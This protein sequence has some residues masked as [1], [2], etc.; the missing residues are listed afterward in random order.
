M[1]VFEF[2]FEGL[3]KHHR[4]TLSLS[5]QFMMTLVKLRLNLCDADLGY[6]FGVHQSTVSRLVLKWID[7]MY[8]RLTPL[9]KWPERGDLQKSL[10]SDFS[11]N[12]QRCVCII[13]CFEIFCQRPSDLMARAL[14]YSHYKS[15][16]TVKYLSGIAPQ[17]VI[18]FAN[19][20][21]VEEQ[22]TSSSQKTVV[23]WISFCQE[24]R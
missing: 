19:R 16:N 6:R 3:K 5:S 17:G 1:V 15:H 10:P 18:T 11:K 2:V 7:I 14:T 20:H 12:F 9:V 23:C 4:S 8:I 13:D 24:I 22:L 21:G